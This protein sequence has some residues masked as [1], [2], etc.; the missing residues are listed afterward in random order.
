[1]ISNSLYMHLDPDPREAVRKFYTLG[2]RNL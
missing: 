1:L 2:G